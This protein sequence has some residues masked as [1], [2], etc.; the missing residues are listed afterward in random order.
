MHLT[1]HFSARDF[2][3]ALG[4]NVIISYEV[5][6][7]RACHM[8]LTWTLVTSDHALAEASD[9][10]GI[11]HVPCA[12]IFVMAMKLSVFKGPPRFFLKHGHG[13]LANGGEWI[14]DPGCTGRQHMEGLMGLLV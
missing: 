6:G 11:G 14:F 1:H 12:F 10:I 2:A 3:A 13:P 9:I 8:L 7:I 4:G 5:E